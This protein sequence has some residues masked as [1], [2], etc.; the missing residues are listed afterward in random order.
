MR[1]QT[2]SIFFSLLFSIVSVTANAQSLKGDLN[3]DGLVNAG[4]MTS[5]VNK[6]LGL[7]EG[8]S[9]YDLNDDGKTNITD[10]VCLISIIVNQQISSFQTCPDDHHPHMIDLGLPSGV[11][12]SCCN[13]GSITPEGLGDYYA[14]AETEEKE[15]YSWSTYLYCDGNQETCQLL[16]NITG[17][18][19]DVAHVKWGSAWRMPTGDEA[20]ELRSNCSVETITYSNLVFDKFTGPNGNSIFIP[21]AGSMWYASN[22]E[23]GEQLWYWTSDQH[24]NRSSAQYLRQTGIM[25]FCWLFEGLPVRPVYDPSFFFSLS[26]DTVDMFVNST[27]DVRIE[28]GSGEY[29]L[30]YDQTDIIDAELIKA[31][32]EEDSDAKDEISIYGVAEGTATLHVLDKS[33]NKTATLVVNVKTPTEED[34][35]T[36][37]EYVAKVRDHINSLGEISVDFFQSDLLSWLDKQ[38]W[39]KEVNT[40]SDYLVPKTSLG[41]NDIV[42]LIKITFENNAIFSILLDYAA[43]NYTDKFF[44]DLESYLTLSRIVDVSYIEGEDIIDNTNVL[45]IQG[46]TMLS[47]KEQNKSTAEKENSMIQTFQQSSPVNFKLTPVFKS[48]SFLEQNMNDFGMILLGQTHGGFEYNSN[49]SGWFQ[50]EDQYINNILNCGITIDIKNHMI[51]ESNKEPNIYCVSPFLIGKRNIKDNT[52]FWGS[53]CY[54]YFMQKH[55]PNTTF[56]GYLTKENYFAGST[57]M[58]EFFYNMSLGMTYK[59]AI[60]NKNPITK[61]TNPIN[62]EYD[63]SN[64]NDEIVHVVPATN[65]P[66]SKQRYFSIST[67]DV[68]EKSNYHPVIKGKING[69]KNLKSNIFLYV[70]VYEKEEEFNVEDLNKNMRWIPTKNIGEDGSFTYEYV[71]FPLTEYP[72]EFKVFVAINYRGNIYHGPIKTLK[73]KGMCPNKNH[74]HWINLGYSSKTEWRCCNEGAS[75]PEDYGNYFTFGQVSSAP[76]YEQARELSLESK[77]WGGTLNGVKGRLVIGPNGNCIFLPAAGQGDGQGDGQYV[78][79]YCFYWTTQPYGEDNGYYFRYLSDDYK[80]INYGPSFYEFPVRS[81]R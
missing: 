63:F 28:M 45:Y 44:S 24:S 36:T 57:Q 8:S 9:A 15:K 13:V 40:Y 56:F 42:G 70:Y 64:Q 18:T 61:K 12:W 54:S 39:V 10:V 32:T 17:T 22:N 29:E 47:F 76:S 79:S 65:H 48:L 34:I 49:H 58:A 73:T 33:C 68:T 21:Y 38:K 72:K 53:Y 80:D 20:D 23:I 4:D 66:E 11:K 31:D 81:V 67:E 51:G 37:K 50:V 41:L 78:G 60:E 7:A 55:I 5:L 62:K 1:R 77:F 14:W 6:I 2:I 75:T 3:G 30:Q 35:T 46:R 59:E 69:F 71:G 26:E 43:S 19:Y 52:I 16:G 25:G 74:P 27:T